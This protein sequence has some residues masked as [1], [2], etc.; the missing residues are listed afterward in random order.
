MNSVT[1]H[2]PYSWNKGS[3]VKNKREGRVIYGKCFILGLIYSISWYGSID[4]YFSFIVLGKTTDHKVLPLLI[5][6]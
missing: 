1:I 2:G 4:M 6:H 5:P 3:L